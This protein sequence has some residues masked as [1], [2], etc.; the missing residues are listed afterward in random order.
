MA[1]IFNYKLQPAEKCRFSISKSGYKNIAWFWLT[2]SHYYI[3]LGNVKLFESSKEWQ[4][5]YPSDCPY[6]EYPYIRQLEDLFDILPQIAAGISQTAYRFIYTKGSWE[7]LLREV[8][9][10]YEVVGDNTTEEQENVYSDLIYF[11]YHGCLNTGY[12]RFKSLL[13]FYH[14]GDKVIIRYDFTDKNEDGLPVWSASHGKFEITW[15]E[16]LYE[17]EN[18]LN[19]FFTDMD[20][21]VEDAVCNLMNNDYYREFNMKDFRTGEKTN[22]INALRKEH[23]ER[24]EYFYSILDKVKKGDYKPDIDF[25]EIVKQ[26]EFIRKDLLSKILDKPRILVDFNELIEEDLILLSQKDTKADSAG[27]E[28]SFCEGMPVGIYSDDNLDENDHID[29]IIADGTA[30]RTP[31]EWQQNY[32]HVKWCCRIVGEYGKYDPQTDN[33][34]ENK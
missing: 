10:W 30:I 2:D 23:R 17:I 29:C 16:F 6:D 24:K 28:I 12:L 4:D 22:A 34:K 15:T 1:D 11:L 25:E 7:W 26:I 3:Q 20:K 14:V 32:G 33:N 18:L 27:N 5:M 8:E 9:Q 19:R 13:F 31:P 21:Q